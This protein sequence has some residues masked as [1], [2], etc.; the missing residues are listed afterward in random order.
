MLEL[1]SSIQIPFCQIRLRSITCHFPVKNLHLITYS[2]RIGINKT[3]WGH[4]LKNLN[5]Q[6][7]RRGHLGCKYVCNEVVDVRLG[8]F[9]FISLKNQFQKASQTS[10]RYWKRIPNFRTLVEYCKSFM[11]STTVM[12]SIAIDAQFCKYG[13][14]VFSIVWVGNSSHNTF[15]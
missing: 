3:Y 11:I 14:T 15:L 10:D 5:H 6:T 1:C 9:G 7:Y 8:Q 12:W 2:N 13:G 4:C